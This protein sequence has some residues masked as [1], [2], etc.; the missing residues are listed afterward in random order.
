MAQTMYFPL[1]ETF[2]RNS[3][4]RGPFT[5]TFFFGVSMVP[6]RSEFSTVIGSVPSS[7]FQEICEQLQAKCQGYQAGSQSVSKACFTPT[8]TGAIHLFVFK[9]F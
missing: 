1:A 6:E 3:I 2:H 5:G 9:I 4:F 8:F 7:D